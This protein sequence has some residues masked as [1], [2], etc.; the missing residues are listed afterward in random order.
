LRA[1]KALSERRRKKRNVCFSRAAQEKSFDEGIGEKREKC[2]LFEDG[3]GKVLRRRLQEKREVCGPIKRTALK[4]REEKERGL[5]THHSALHCE[6]EKKN[7]RKSERS[8]DP[9]KRTALRRNCTEKK[10]TAVRRSALRRSGLRTHQ[11][12]LH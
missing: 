4:M 2:E 5:R 3:S 11:S 9:S 10:R 12:A 1:E 7:R 8:A 6:C